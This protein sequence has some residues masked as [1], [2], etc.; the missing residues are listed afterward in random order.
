MF[1]RNVPIKIKKNHSETKGANYEWQTLSRN[2]AKLYK[3]FF[4]QISL[5][6]RPPTDGNFTL[7]QH[8]YVKSSK[9]LSNFIISLVVEFV[10]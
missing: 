9:S 3:Y 1:V 2:N 10:I 5:T 7:I 8:K 6:C 4:Q